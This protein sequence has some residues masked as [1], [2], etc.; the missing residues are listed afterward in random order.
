M[1]SLAYNSDY[2]LNAICPYF[3]MFPLEFPVKVLKRNWSQNTV[4]MD[5]FCGRGTTLFAARKLGLKS[6]GVDASPVAVAVAQAKLAKIAPTRAMTLAEEFLNLELEEEV[7]RTEF[8]RKAFHRDVL[9]KLC[10]LRQ[11]LIR[12]EKE[13]NSSVLLRAAILGCLHGP[14]PKSATGHAYFSNQLP[15]TFAPKPD[16][17]VKFWAEKQMKAPKVNVLTVLKRKIARIAAGENEGETNIDNVILGDSCDPST[18]PRRCQD[19]SVVI[20]S[21]PYYGMRTYIQDQWLRHWFLG[22]LDHVVYDTGCQLQHNGPDGFAKSLG[23]VWKNMAQSRADDLRMFIRFGVVPSV[24]VDAK[25][26]MYAS[27]EDS[28]VNWKVVSIR[29]ADT[30]NIGKRQADQMGTGSVAAVEYDFHVV[31]A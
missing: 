17:S 25:E 16:Y 27:F 11:G 23:K 1:S 13:T 15:R 24:K 8:F 12:L 4:V 5:P 20:T 14:L 21:P 10:Q 19:F 22:G 30:A 9:H 6:W 18:Y 29:G 3:T 31:R 7:P 2:A 28:G 26:V